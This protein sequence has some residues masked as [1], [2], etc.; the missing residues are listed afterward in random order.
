ML[1]Y[2]SHHMLPIAPRYEK[3]LVDAKVSPFTSAGKCTMFSSVTGQKLDPADCSPSYWK[4]NMVSTVLFAPALTECLKVH[5]QTS[6]ILEVGPHAALKGPALETL[7]TLDNNSIEYHHSLIREKRDLDA[8]LGS[9]GA[10]IVRGIPLETAN[11]N[12]QEI[13]NGL[14]CT[15]KHGSVLRDLP[16]YQ[17]DHSTS[18]WSESRV[19]R[20]VRHRKFPRHQLLGSRYV[21]DIPSH[22]S[23]RNHLMLKEVPWLMEL[24]VYRFS[25]CLV[26]NTEQSS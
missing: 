15:Y 13:V 4:Q 25:R 8:L 1:A 7:R 11:I 14:Q 5:P 19:S 23:W 17:W 21:E 9:A 18:F 22:P 2:H 3:A 26:S 24:K 16:S 12:G 10:M 20:N 6:T